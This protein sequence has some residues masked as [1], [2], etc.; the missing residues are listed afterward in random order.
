MTDIIP[1]SAN[2]AAFCDRFPEGRLCRLVNRRS[3]TLLDIQ[4]NLT[5]V[6]DNVPQVV[7]KHKSR[8]FIPPVS[9]QLETGNAES[10]GVQYWMI[11]PHGDGQAIIPVP[12]DDSS[13]V[14]YLS[15][16]SLNTD[17][18]ITISPFPASF[19]IF[20]TSDCPKLGDSPLTSFSEPQGL[21]D[22]WTCQIS[23]PHF[24]NTEPR[25]LDL[26]AGTPTANNKVVLYPYSGTQWQF[27]LIQ[28]IRYRARN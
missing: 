18:P 12:K 11:V 21:Y 15:P 17:R 27:W 19:S 22:Q 16:S 4:P 24:R 2:Q 3:G 23:W 28:F 20:P 7:G 9:T 1:L 10:A 5:L 25:M 26:W 13:T 8:L 6:N 14:R